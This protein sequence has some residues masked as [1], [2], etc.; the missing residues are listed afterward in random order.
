MSR[1]GA[2]GEQAGPE[3]H[4]GER[5]R[6]VAGVDVERRRARS[7]STAARSSPGDCPCAASQ[8]AEGSSCVGRGSAGSTRRSASAARPHAASRSPRPRCAVR[9]ERAARG[10]AAPAGWP[11]RSRREP[12]AGREHRHVETVLQDDAV[13]RADAGRGSR[14]RRCSSAGTRAGRCRTAGRGARRTRWPRRAA[15]ARSSSVTSAPRSASWIAAA[16][17]ASPPPTTTTRV[18]PARRTRS[19]RHPG[20]APGRDPRLLPGGQRLAA[21]EHRLGVGGD[22]HSSRR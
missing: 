6:R 17:P 15:A 8:L 14:G 5:E 4:R 13:A 9:G 12:A 10:A 1:R 22:A 21:V 20:E 2:F 19:R 18:S 16:S 7:G 3:H 11:R